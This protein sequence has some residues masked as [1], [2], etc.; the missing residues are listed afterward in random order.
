MV[1]YKFRNS[2]CV[3]IICIIFGLTN[4]SIASIQ[5]TTT[6]QQGAIINSYIYN[7]NEDTYLYIDEPN[8]NYGSSDSMLAGRSDSDEDARII[9]RFDTSALPADAD[10]ISAKLYLYCF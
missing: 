7:G 2:L 3:V 6:F 1:D 9:L 8:I 10:I 5:V 4:V